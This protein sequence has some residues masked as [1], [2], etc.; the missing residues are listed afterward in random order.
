MSCSKGCEMGSCMCCLDCN[1]R[2]EFKC[3]CVRD[4]KAHCIESKKMVS[5]D[6]C[7]DK[8]S[9]I[10][11]DSDMACVNHLTA[12]DAC[13]NNLRANS[14]QQCGKYRA[15]VV[16]GAP[17]AYNLGDLLA[18]DTILDDPNGNVIIGLPW[19]SYTAP[20]SG[21]YMVTVEVDMSAFSIVGDPVLGTPVANPQV[22]VNG[23]SFREAYFS[24]LSFHNSQKSLLSALISLKAGDVV[25]SDYRALALTDAGFTLLVGTAIASGNGSEAAQSVFKIHYLSSDCSEQPMCMPCVAQTECVPCCMVS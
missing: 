18:F 10:K 11:L 7:A 14:F 20:I 12:N 16:Y 2:I 21:Y 13:I 24:F 25:T 3:L 17:A 4:L 22:K 15:T 23:V 9:V 19:M 1:A 5:K 6:L 8:G